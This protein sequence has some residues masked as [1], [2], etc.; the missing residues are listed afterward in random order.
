MT[1][2]KWQSTIISVWL[3]STSEKEKPANIDPQ[4]AG[5]FHSH[6][7]YSNQQPEDKTSLFDAKDF[8]HCPKKLKIIIKDV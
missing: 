5:S 8:Y 7:F 2:Q 1:I 6:Y 3:L 4:A